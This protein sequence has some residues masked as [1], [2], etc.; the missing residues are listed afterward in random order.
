VVLVRRTATKRTGV[1][2]GPATAHEKEA[3]A[4]VVAECRWQR[5]QLLSAIR[6]L[7]ID[8]QRQRNN[9]CRGVFAC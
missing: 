4:V 7:V 2:T 5:E 1:P 8:D 3:D 9:I 6:D